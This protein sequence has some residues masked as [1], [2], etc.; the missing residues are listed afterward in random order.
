MSRRPRGGLGQPGRRVARVAPVVPAAPGPSVGKAL[1]RVQAA[2]VGRASEQ[3]QE[4]WSV[5]AQAVCGLGS[6][7]GPESL[8]VLVRRL[9]TPGTEGTEGSWG[10]RARRE[11]QVELCLHRALE[12]LLSAHPHR[13]SYRASGS[14]SRLVKYCMGMFTYCM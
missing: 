1:A 11:G 6:R 3:G 14:Q 5:T 2:C 8:A 13:A 12:C 4:E 10:G 7:Q 9:L